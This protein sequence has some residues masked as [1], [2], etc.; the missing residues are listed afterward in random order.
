MKLLTKFFAWR[1]RRRHQA[2]KRWLRRNRVVL[3]KP[4]PRCQR[5]GP[6]CV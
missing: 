3:P 6:E 2:H 5:N 4:D 1:T